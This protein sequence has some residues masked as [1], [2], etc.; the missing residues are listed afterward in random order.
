MFTIRKVLRKL[1][2]VRSETFTRP[3]TFGSAPV[4][5]RISPTPRRIPLADEPAPG[6]HHYNLTWG[7]DIMSKSPLLPVRASRGPAMAAALK[8]LHGDK[9]R[10]VHEPNLL[11]RIADGLRELNYPRDCR[12]DDPIRSYGHAYQ[13]MDVHAKHHG[14]PRH[15]AAVAYAQRERS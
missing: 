10:I 7:E 15:V 6:A 2:Q 1:L 14:C 11:Q 9:A 4:P 12:P 3:P 13:I 8:L 5:D